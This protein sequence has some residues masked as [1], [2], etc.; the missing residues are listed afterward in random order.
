M[1][2]LLVGTA[3]VMIVISPALGRD[4]DMG[5]D[6]CKMCPSWRSPASSDPPPWWLPQ[7]PVP[8]CHLVRERVGTRHGHSVYQTRQVCN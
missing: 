1:K 4:N 7:N 8:A 2:M 6:S 5:D 3:L